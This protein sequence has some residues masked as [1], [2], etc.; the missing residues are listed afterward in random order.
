M[1]S[2]LD[3]DEVHG[4]SDLH[5][6]GQPGFQIFGSTEELVWLLDTLSQKPAEQRVAL[7]INGDF[8]DFLAEPGARHFN[9]DKAIGDLERIK[10]DDTFAAIFP[11]IQRFVSTANRTLII[12]LGNHDIELFLPWVQRHLLE[13]LSAGDDSRR[14]RIRLVADG[15]GVSCRVG[16]A[17]VL[18]VHGNEVDDWNRANYEQLRMA[19]RTGQWGGRIDPIEPNAGSKM[20]IEVMNDIKRQYP[21]VDLLKPETEAAIPILLT[22]S[23]E[24]YGKLQPVLSVLGRVGLDKFK[25]HIGWLGEDEALPISD[26]L[27]NSTRPLPSSRQLLDGVEYMAR[28]QAD[29]MALLPGAASQQLGVMDAIRG[30]IQGKSTEEALRRGLDGLDKDQSFNPNAVDDTFTALDE[31]VDPSI[32]FLVAGHTH[33]E[34]SLSRRKGQGSY[35]NSGTWAR[36][37][38]ISPQTRQDPQAFN[39]LINRLIKSRSMGELDQADGLV[40]R[41][42]SVVSI[43]KDGDRTLG[44]L[45]R[46][47]LAAGQKTLI[48]VPNTLR[49]K[50]A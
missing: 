41:R 47:A 6:G 20:V 34:R 42:C 11:A 14:G 21:F 32:D 10:G 37:I 12:N 28:Q 35:F 40:I 36:L 30:L 3:F 17:N 33:L 49:S 27:V 45:R 8:I 29:P 1:V 24:A 23:P 46:V 48:P 19:A 26:A 31:Q 7:V 39:T 2:D 38:Q 44:E 5:I 43:W 22:L 25:S 50:E 9:P 16:K 4:I 18:F 15:T 13:M